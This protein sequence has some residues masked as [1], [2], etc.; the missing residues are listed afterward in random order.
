MTR[1]HQNI[2]AY[3]S[4]LCCSS[5]RPGKRQQLDQPSRVVLDAGSRHG[6]CAGTVQA[7][8]T[9]PRG[10][11]G[12]FF[13]RASS[14][15]LYRVGSRSPV[16]GQGVSGGLQTVVWCGTVGLATTPPAAGGGPG[17]RTSQHPAQL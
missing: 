16:S 10:G 1:V 4:V 5:A 17:L 6:N 3:I 8:V 15:D 2:P 7:L 11:G 14:G 9:C 13:V 12:A